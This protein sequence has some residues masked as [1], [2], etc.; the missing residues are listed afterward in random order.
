MIISITVV[1][2]YLIFLM[3]RVITITMVII[4]LQKRYEKLQ[5]LHFCDDD[6]LLETFALLTRG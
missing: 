4:D 6:V 3:L 2:S 1:R 5:C